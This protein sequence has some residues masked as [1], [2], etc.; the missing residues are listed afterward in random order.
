VT[1]GLILVGMHYINHV[2]SSTVVTEE[3]STLA[4][5]WESLIKALGFCVVNAVNQKAITENE[6]VSLIFDGISLLIF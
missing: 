6:Y 1:D 4:R 2:R 3:I 5:K